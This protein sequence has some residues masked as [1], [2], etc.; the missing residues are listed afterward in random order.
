MKEVRC[1]F[2]WRGFLESIGITAGDQVGMF[3]D[4]RRVNRATDFAMSAAQ[5]GG[6]FETC[7]SPDQVLTWFKATGVK[8][9][10]D[11]SSSLSVRPVHKN[12]AVGS[13]LI[14]VQASQGGR[15]PTLVTI[16]V[17]RS[18]NPADGPPNAMPPIFGL[19]LKVG[20]ADSRWQTISS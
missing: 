10:E 18:A 9:V 15:Q 1:S 6:S 19:L 8:V 7:C 16:S 13:E 4:L 14:T 17:Q 12:G 20:M 5:R 11:G 3:S 2:S